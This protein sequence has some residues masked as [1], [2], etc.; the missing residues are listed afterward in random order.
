MPI[1]PRN[2]LTDDPQARFFLAPETPQ[3]RQYEALR[4]YFVEKAPSHEVAR[5]FGYT[6]G[7]FGVLCHQLRHDPAKRAAFLP[8][9]TLGPHT[10]PKRDRVRNLA[11]AMRKRNLSVYDIRRELADAGHTISINALS[12]LLREEGFARLPR[13]LDEE[14]PQ[15][16]RPEAAAMA[17][18]RALSLVP[19]SFR[20]RL[21]GLWL[22]V[23]LMRDIRLAEVLRTADLPGSAMIPA[24][25]AVRTLLALKLVGKERK[26]HVMDLVCDEGVALFAGLNVVPKRSYLAAYSS[27]VDRRTNMQLLGAWSDEVHRVGLPRGPPA[28]LVFASQLTPHA[29]LNRLNQ[30]GVRFMTLRR[31][32][33][34]ML[35]A[36]WSR[37]AEAG[38]RIILNSLTR[39]FRTPRVLDERIRLKGYEGELRQ[40]TIIDLGH[41]EP[42][43]LLTNNFQS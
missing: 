5:R 3:H 12:V 11:V 41:E 13:R 21:G 35:G 17:D 9:Y 33:R 40:V 24:E 42:T 36:I 39:S 32:T 8:P 16:L 30:R 43:V 27:R 28:E 20:T 25:Q 38:R 23:P 37:P 31:R 10:A 14:R 18:V 26:S 19:R 7:A 22:F 6:P 1:S 29:T 34:A 4:A 2:A 15:T